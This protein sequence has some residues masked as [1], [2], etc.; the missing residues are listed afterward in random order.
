MSNPKKNAKFYCNNDGTITH[1]YYKF[2][3]ECKDG[4]FGLRCQY[5]FFS[6][7][8]ERCNIGEFYAKGCRTCPKGTIS[9]GSDVKCLPCIPGTYSPGKSEKCFN[10][11]SSKKFESKNCDLLNG[12]NI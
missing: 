6:L 8:T 2:Y 3:C 7:I 5:S 4:F 10:C 12:T 1:N 9:N 11:Q